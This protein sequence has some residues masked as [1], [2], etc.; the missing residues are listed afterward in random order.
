MKPSDYKYLDNSKAAFID[1]AIQR[2]ADSGKMNYSFT[3]SDEEIKQGLQRQRLH[4]QTI[5]DVVEYFNEEGMQAEYDDK[6][7]RVRVNLNLHEVTMS[8]REAEFL[9]TAISQFRVEHT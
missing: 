9:S 5:A 7:A 8:P 3:L 2:V 1:S 6:R 4:E